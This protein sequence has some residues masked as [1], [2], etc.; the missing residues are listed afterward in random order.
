MGYYNEIK[1]CHEHA[2][3]D[4]YA[5]DTNLENLENWIEGKKFSETALNH[6]RQYKRVCIVL[7]IFVEEEFRGQGI[8]SA[9][10]EEVIGEAESNGADVIILE[11]DTGE[12]NA[13]SLVD[14]YKDYGFHVLEGEET[15]YPL[16]V[17][18]F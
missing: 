5:V 11:V 14:W 15:N 3:L 7:G 10:L 17:Y 16:M 12:N 2:G 13:F 1:I 8:G 6:L 4:A 18:Y 9:L